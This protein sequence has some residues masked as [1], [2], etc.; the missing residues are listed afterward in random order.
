MQL[1]LKDSYLNAILTFDVD[2]ADIILIIFVEDYNNLF[3]VLV[4]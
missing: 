3:T 1:M 4:N 2:I